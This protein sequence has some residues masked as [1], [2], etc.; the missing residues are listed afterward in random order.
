[1]TLPLTHRLGACSSA[2]QASVF[3]S[4]TGRAAVVGGVNDMVRVEPVLCRGPDVSAEVVSRVPPRTLLGR[5]G[6]D[7][8]P[9]PGWPLP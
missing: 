5:L 1:M 2:R 6:A 4:T 9:P 8:C 3:S 7:P